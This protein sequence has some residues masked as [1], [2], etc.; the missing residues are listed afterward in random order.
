M[1]VYLFPICWIFI[2]DTMAKKMKTHVFFVRYDPPAPREPW[3]AGAYVVYFIPAKWNGFNCIASDC[4]ECITKKC[5]KYTAGERRVIVD[6][7]GLTALKADKRIVITRILRLCY[8]L[9]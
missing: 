4:Y 5:T 8:I 7:D 6:K 1:G 9:T 3:R 2:I